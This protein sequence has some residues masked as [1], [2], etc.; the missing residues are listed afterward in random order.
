MTT[1]CGLKRSGAILLT[2]DLYYSAG[3]Y[4]L[5]EVPKHNSSAAETLASFAHFRTLAKSLHA[6]VIIQHEPADVLKLPPFPNA[7]E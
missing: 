2:G 6:T 1:C 7:A 4:A 5:D 3:Q